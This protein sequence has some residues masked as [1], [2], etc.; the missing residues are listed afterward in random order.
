[1]RALYAALCVLGTILPYG[2]FAPFLIEQ[3]AA[4]GLL[5]RELFGSPVPAFFGWDVIVSS[6]VLW[7]FVFAEGRRLGMTHLWVYVAANLAVGVSLALPLFLWAREGGRRAA[8]ARAAGP[9]GP[10]L[11]DVDCVSLPVADLDAA[12]DFWRTR[13]GHELIWRTESAAGLR[14]PDCASEL[15]IHTENRPAAAELAVHAVPAAVERFRAAGGATL[16]PPF[17]IAIGQCA[18][19]RDPWDNAL[20]LLDRS[21]GLLV[22]DDAGNVM[23]D[24]REI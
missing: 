23:P 8:A 10:L 5:V 1:M 11:R 12:L 7:I 22:T 6:L 21:K 20:V 3:G 4:P 18:V 24:V 9:R 15:V 16:V 19:V 2:A 17:E 14:L 13:L